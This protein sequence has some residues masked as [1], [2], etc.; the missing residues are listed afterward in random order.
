[1]RKD[2]ERPIPT[3]TFLDNTI[4][5]IENKTFQLAYPGPYHQRGNI[6]IYLPEQKVLMAVDQ[7]ASGEV[8]WKHLAATPDVTALM[9]SYD[10]ALA[11]DFDVYVSGHGNTGTKEDIKIQEEYIN[12][13]KLTLNL[14]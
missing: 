14:R 6:F 11:Y 13:L 10:Q 12:D 3:K 2:S 4:L 8:P 5:T 7:L 9:R 1:M